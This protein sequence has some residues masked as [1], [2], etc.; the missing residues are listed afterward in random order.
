MDSAVVLLSG[1]IASATAAYRRR[2]SSKL[3]LLYLNY[4]AQAAEPESQAATALAEALKTNLTVLDLPHV[5]EIARLRQANHTTNRPSRQAPITGPDDIAGLHPVLLSVGAQ[6]AAA[7][8]AQ[9]LVTGHNAPSLDA[10]GQQLSLERSVDPRQ[11]HHA[12]AAMLETALPTVRAVQ[13]ESPLL[14]LT[15]GEILKLANRFNLPTEAT[16]SCQTKGPPCGTCPGCQSRK[17]A[18]ATAGR[19]DPLLSPASR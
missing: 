11:F 2:Q 15:P 12:F 19:A 10:T 14:D 9:W 18:F 6:F 17:T 4:G 7:V 16:W 1:G 3:H 5:V 8:G 13:L